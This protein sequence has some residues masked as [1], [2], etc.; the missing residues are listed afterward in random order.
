MYKLI[1]R[2]FFFLFG[3][4]LI[5]N[6]SFLLIKLLCRIPI[7]SN[8]IKYNF[9]FKNSLLEKQLFGLNFKNRIGMAAGFDKNALL[10]YEL[11]YFG[12]GH[13]EVGTITPKAQAGNDK[14]RLF[15]LRKDKALINRMGFNNHGVDQIKKRLKK[16]KGDLIIG[17]NIGKNKLTPNSK[18]VDDYLICFKKLRNHVDYF[19]IN[20]SSPNTPDLRKLQDKNNLSLILEKIQNENYSRKE[21]KPVLLK[22]SPDLSNIELDDIIEVSIKYKIDGIIATNTT[23]SRKNIISRKNKLESGGLS[24]SPVKNRSNEIISYINMKSNNKLKIIGVGGVFTSEDVINKI[25]IGASLVQVYT[26]WIYEGPGMISR[27][28]KTLLKKEKK[29]ILSK[30]YS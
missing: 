21:K 19:V 14:P 11:N 3:P 20:V 4:E 26:G 10:L 27:I 18:A 13:V 5:H 8:L 29:N 16:Y 30:I 28:N 17:A 1:I 23:I 22:I 7:I 12:F 25:N 2:P 6:F 9:T 15:R 24:G